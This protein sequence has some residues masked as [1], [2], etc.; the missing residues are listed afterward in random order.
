MEYGFC[1]TPGAECINN[2]YTCFPTHKL[3]FIK[4]TICAEKMSPHAYKQQTFFKYSCRCDDEVDIKYKGREVRVKHFKFRM[5]TKFPQ[6]QIYK[7]I[8]RLCEI[9]F[10]ILLLHWGHNFLVN[11]L[12]I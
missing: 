7:P 5:L 1:F 3:R 2:V 8:F 6:R 10:I 4:G 12:F 9:N 11:D